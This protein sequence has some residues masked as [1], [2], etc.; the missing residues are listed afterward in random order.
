MVGCVYAVTGKKKFILQF[1][2]VQ[3]KQIRASS[4]VILI[5]KDYINMD[6]PLSK[7]HEK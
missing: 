3:N 5:S 6:K 7:S 4:L 1:K 2:Y